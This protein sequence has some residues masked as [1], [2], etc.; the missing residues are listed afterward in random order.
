MPDLVKFHHEGVLWSM[1]VGTGVIGMI[2]C[3]SGRRGPNGKDEVVFGLCKEGLSR[4]IYLGGIPCIVCHPENNERFWLEGGEAIRMK[5][6]FVD[7]AAFTDKKI[8]PFDTRR[9]D[10]DWIVKNLGGLPG[11]LYIPA[12]LDQDEVRAFADDLAKLGVGVPEI[13]YYDWKSKTRFGLYLAA[14]RAKL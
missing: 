13:G 9:M 8:L 1:R 11:R 7:P 14:S 4:L 10:F 3:K 2:D 5:Y 12:G 6:D